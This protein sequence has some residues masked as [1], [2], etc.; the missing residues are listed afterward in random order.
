L[1][2]RR[3]E[4]PPALRRMAKTAMTNSAADTDV[5]HRPVKAPHAPRTAKTD[6]YSPASLVNIDAMTS[7]A[8]SC[9]LCWRR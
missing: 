7:R 5:C 3:N 1:E 2:E 9:R 8:V 4:M 6:R